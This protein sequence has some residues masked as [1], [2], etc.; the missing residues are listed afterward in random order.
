MIVIWKW[1]SSSRGL[2][3]C[4]TCSWT[5]L[6]WWRLRGRQLVGLRMSLVRQLTMWSKGVNSWQKQR[7]RKSVEESSN[8]Y[9][10]AL[11]P[12]LLLSYSSS[13]FLPF[14]TFERSQ[15][16]FLAS[17]DALEVMFVTD[18]LTY[19]LIDSTDFTDVT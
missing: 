6:S 3:R 15:C 8:S 13:F 1:S 5:F 2:R 16:T 10:L 7:R 9:W 14:E 12:V 19:L 18:S 11:V 4:M 17:Q